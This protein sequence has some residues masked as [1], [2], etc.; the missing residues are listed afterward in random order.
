MTVNANPT[1]QITGDDAICAGETS[2]LDAGA[3]FVAYSWNTGGAAQTLSANTAG[4]YTVTVTDGNG[5]VGTDTFVLTVNANPTPT[6]TGTLEFCTGFSTVLNAGTYTAYQWSVAGQTAQNLTVNSGGTFT[7]TVTDA[8]GCTGIDDATTIMNANLT[9]NIT[10]T[11]GICAGETATLNV[12]TYTTY[13]WSVA[14]QSNATLVTT[15]AGTYTVTVTDVNGCTGVDN[16]TVALNPDPLPNFTSTAAICVG[17]EAIFT[18]TGSTGVVTYNWNFGSAGT[19][20][21]VGPHTVVFN[22]V[23]TQTVSLD[24]V[25]ANGCENTVSHTIVVSEV[26]ATVNANVE[27]LLFGNNSTLQA[28]ATSAGNG[29]LTYQWNPTGLDCADVAC[30]QITVSP[31]STTLYTVTVTD[32]YGCEATADKLITV[33]RENELIVP[34]AFSPNGDGINDLF[35]FDG[36]NIRQIEL[37]VF[38]RWGQKMFDG[39][40]DKTL[41]WNGE[42][43]GKKMEL[44]VYVYQAT[45]YFADDT[46][47]FVKGNVTLLW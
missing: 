10:G 41:G 14:G 36:V 8:N 34:N 44:G 9:P 26:E 23:G 4:T 16:F 29:D 15:N 47:E 12:G 40:G 43:K 35:R 46:K 45:V 31:D 33:Y 20:T 24:V 25:D 1:P 11:D 30:S 5:C 18:Y 7:V 42:Y 22:T 17:N 38:D 27:L 32:E 6:I 28:I 13:Q 19:A 3:G 39:K 2:T 21:G 37:Q